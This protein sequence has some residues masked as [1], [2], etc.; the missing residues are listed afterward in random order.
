MGSA[1][2]TGVAVAPTG[3]CYI[4]GF[5]YGSTTFGAVTLPG[6]S[7]Q[8]QN[9]DVFLTKYD[10]DGNVL[11]ANQINNPLEVTPGV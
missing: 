9:K 1:V 8:G 11:W 3:G 2:G 10:A 5:F 7:N 4:T 6:N